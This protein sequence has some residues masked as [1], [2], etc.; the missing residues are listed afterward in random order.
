M[1]GFRRHGLVHISQIS[2]ERV[3]NVGDVVS[4]GDRVYVKVIKIDTVGSE[5][6][7]GLSMKVRIRAPRS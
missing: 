3:E 7:I 4:V 6:K 1:E 5:S 2:R